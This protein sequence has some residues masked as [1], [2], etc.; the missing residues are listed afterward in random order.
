MIAAAAPETSSG[1]IQSV[2]ETISSS[3]GKPARRTPT[4]APV[5]PSAE[6]TY[7]CT[8]C[9]RL[10]VFQLAAVSLGLMMLTLIPSIRSRRAN[11]IVARVLE[12]QRS[13]KVGHRNRAHEHQT[14]NR[15]EVE[16]G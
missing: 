14:R 6:L 4:S 11:A 7:S 3:R 13:A 15:V 12:R 9:S 2:V 1:L 10:L 5:S 16:A 8:T